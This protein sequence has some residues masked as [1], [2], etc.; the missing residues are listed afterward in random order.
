MTA[1]RAMAYNGNFDAALK[2]ATGMQTSSPEEK[3]TLL[4]FMAGQW[5]SYDP[6]KAAQWVQTLPDGPDRDQ[7]LIGL[8]ASWA[9]KDPP[10]AADFAAKLPA[11]TGRQTALKQAIEDWIV[12]DPVA[13]A[14]WINAFPPQE[15]L[16]QAVASVATL[17]SLVDEHV[18]VALSWA[19]TIVNDSLRTTALS[20]ILSNWATRDPSAALNY[21]QTAPGLSDEA[22][23]QLVQQLQPSGQ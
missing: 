12:A 4:N 23:A 13:A 17:R 21:A 3:T 11:G 10:G 2:L 16:D 20:E 19:S 15:D 14:T 9:E 6:E 7:A 5:A 8:G 22:R 18:D 1:M